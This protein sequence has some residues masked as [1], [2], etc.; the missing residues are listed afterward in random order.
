MSIKQIHAG[1]DI[2]APKMKNFQDFIQLMGSPSVWFFSYTHFL[3]CTCHFQPNIFSEV[4]VILSS[5]SDTFWKF[6]ELIISSHTWNT[7]FLNWPYLTLSSPT[8]VP[9]FLLQACLV[10]YLVFLFQQHGSCYIKCLSVMGLLPSTSW[11]KVIWQIQSWKH[12]VGLSLPEETQYLKYTR[13]QPNLTA[14]TTLWNPILLVFQGL[15]N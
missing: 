2:N 9:M 3:C 7:T 12:S 13:F 11:S 8:S 4:T 1:M 14:W 15:L 6:Y 5:Y 10:Q